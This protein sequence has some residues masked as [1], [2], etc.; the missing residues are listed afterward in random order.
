[1][2]KLGFI[3]LLLCISNIVVAGTSSNDT[4]IT[5]ISLV[6]EYGEFAFIKLAT[7]PARSDC[8]KNNH[9]DYTVSLETDFGRA[10][11]STVLAAFLADKTISMSGVS[12]GLCNEFG[13]VE[14]MNT[15]QI[16]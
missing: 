15:I 9:W 16:N 7:P 14:S 3:G 11:Y 10:Q 4:K 2:N 6:Q 5:N 1:M 12:N 8:S 13:S